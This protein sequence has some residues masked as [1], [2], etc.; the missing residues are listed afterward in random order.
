MSAIYTAANG[1]AKSLNQL[2]NPL[3]HWGQGSNPHPHGYQWSS[4]PLS[5]NG[6]PLYY[7]SHSIL[8]NPH[9]MWESTTQGYDYQEV[10]NI[11]GLLGA[12][13]SHYLTEKRPA[14]RHYWPITQTGRG[15][16]SR[17]WA[18]SEIIINIPSFIQ[19]CLFYL[20]MSSL[21]L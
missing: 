18:Q 21:Y 7:C 17:I 8:F 9:T 11:R 19:F 10:G 5:H 2:S 15:S 13:P 16:A 1:S 3:I 20:S 12:C 4:L 14:R 6:T